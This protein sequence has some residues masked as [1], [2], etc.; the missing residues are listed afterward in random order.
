MEYSTSEAFAANGTVR[1]EGLTT[2]FLSD[3]SND[4]GV[5]VGVYET[6]ITGLQVKLLLITDVDRS[7]LISCWLQTCP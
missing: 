3:R 4:V 6:D 1:V 7:V 5:T 2:D